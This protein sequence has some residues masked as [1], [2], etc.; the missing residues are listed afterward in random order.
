VL[1]SR[2]FLHGRTEPAPGIK[3]IA[4][5]DERAESISPEA[6]NNPEQ[7]VLTV[8]RAEEIPDGAVDILTLCLNPSNEDRRFL[9]PPPTLPAR[10]L[11]DSTKPEMA[12]EPVVSNNEI[13]VRAHGAVLIAARYRAK[14][15]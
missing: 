11:V 15:T 1:R 5:F 8:R 4:W 7:R 10:V 9:L 14:P 13:E 6:W 2:R 12:D 3:D